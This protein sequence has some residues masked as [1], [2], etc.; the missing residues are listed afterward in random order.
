MG[1]IRANRVASQQGA[2]SQVQQQ[3]VRAREATYYQR[4]YG[5]SEPAPEARSET[6]ADSRMESRGA[7]SQQSA[8]Y[9]QQQYYDQSAY[10]QQAYDQQG[11]DEAYAEAGYDPQGYAQAQQAQQP[12]PRQQARQQSQKNQSY[13]H[14]R[15]QPQ[16]N[17]D[18]TYQQAQ[19]YQQ[20]AQAHWDEAP[21][22]TL[23]LALHLAS[24]D[25]RLGR[26]EAALGQLNQTIHNVSA[27]QTSQGVTYNKRLVTMACVM[28]IGLGVVAL[29]PRAF[30]EQMVTAKVNKAMQVLASNMATSVPSAMA[31]TQPQAPLLAQQPYTQQQMQQRAYQQPAQRMPQQQQQR[32]IQPGSS[33]QQPAYLPNNTGAALGASVTPPATRSAAVP[34]PPAPPIRV[35]QV[36]TPFQNKIRAKMAKNGEIIPSQWQPM[37]DREAKGDLKGKLQ[38]A[39][40]FLKGEEVTRDQAFAVELIREAGAAGEKEA[41]MW[42]ASAYQAGNLGQTDLTQAA[43]WYEVA[44]KAGVTK[45]FTE[46][47]K[48]YEA[49]ID[50]APDTDT[51]LAWYQR[52][53]QAGDIPGAEA[54]QRIARAQA[55]VTPSQTLASAVPAMPAPAVAQ[56]APQQVASADTN[57]ASQILFSNEPRPA[58]ASVA[59][60]APA[61]VRAMGEMVVADTA[62][63]AAANM[64]ITQPLEEGSTMNVSM[65]N[66]N[67][68][69]AVQRM[70]KALGYKIDRVDGLTGPQ[71]SNAIRAYQRAK[72]LYPDGET[73]PQLM[74][75][76]MNDMRW[77]NQ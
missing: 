21:N 2:N 27:A 15:N 77:G 28:A 48:I 10:D 40:K 74:E 18:A 11:Y 73:G 56:P 72:M 66:T 43:H 4:Q 67:D 55:R 49:G 25:T 20:Q 45:A 1:I 17:N 33:L 50:G 19:Q 35:A 65:E 59:M 64:P 8:S 71:T 62:V 13:S 36:F 41:A 47:G 57:Q 61:P 52:A 16:T 5:D 23:D 69:R 31:A 54:V 38:V 3:R 37:F 39:A 30:S 29:V 68:V 60:M 63:P 76:L 51:A 26:L 22:E 24:H 34:T 58:P 6:R 7:R 44:G 14:S 12:Q 42:L 46:L 53:A 75:S 32:M 70:L 9:S